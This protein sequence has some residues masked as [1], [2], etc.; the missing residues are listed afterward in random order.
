RQYKIFNDFGLY[1]QDQVLLNLSSQ[2]TQN[3]IS[4]VKNRLNTKSEK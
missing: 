2:E 3:L 4:K 1:E